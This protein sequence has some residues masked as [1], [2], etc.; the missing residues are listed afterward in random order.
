MTGAR[1]RPGFFIPMVS[2]I[3]TVT[4]LAL[5]AITHAQLWWGAGSL[6]RVE[7]LRS[8]LQEQQAHNDASRR[9]NERLNSEVEDLKSGQDMIEEKART[10]LGMVKPH[11]IYVQI[12]R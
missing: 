4:L 2:R 7:D 1:Y 12:L 5:L 8:Q 10:E 11:E 9:A 6:S 3:V